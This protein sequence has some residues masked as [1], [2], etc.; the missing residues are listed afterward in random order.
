MTAKGRSLPV[1]AQHP[2]L[3]LSARNQSYRPGFLIFKS[4]RLLLRQ[5]LAGHSA[6]NGQKRTI[7]AQKKPVEAGS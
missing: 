2:E 3:P 5:L 4:E 6:E 1:A 7:A